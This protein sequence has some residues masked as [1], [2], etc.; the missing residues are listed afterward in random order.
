M[1]P[2]IESRISSKRA[3]LQELDRE[4][5][6]VEAELR[7]YEDM[8]NHLESPASQNGKLVVEAVRSG[9][10]VDRASSIPS[11]M[12]PSWRKILS[13]LDGMGRSFDAA[14]IVKVADSVGEPTKMV[15]AR[16]QLYQWEKKHIIQRVR[17]GRYKLAPKGQETVRKNEGPDAVTSGPQEITLPSDQTGRSSRPE[18]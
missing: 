1:R 18:F 9:R 12:T 5:L 15:N 6:A 8:L 17:K 2:Y 16:S 4:K 10:S 14:E 13:A 7:A 3:R 11:E